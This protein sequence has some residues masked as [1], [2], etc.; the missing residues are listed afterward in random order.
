MTTI[1][2]SIV[3]DA[4][5][6]QIRPIFFDPAAL[7]ARDANVTRYEPDAD[8]PTPGARFVSTFKTFVATVEAVATCLSYDPQT[9]RLEFESLATNI[10][11]AT[12]SHWLYTFDEHD[13]RTT[14]TLRLEYHLSDSLLGQM[15]DRLLVERQNNKQVAASLAGLKQQ[16]EAAVAEAA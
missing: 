10:D 7:L 4:T 11:G 2:Q 3:I 13:G 14:V 8:W 1:N 16:V 5:R 6:E 15:L 12:P 9:M